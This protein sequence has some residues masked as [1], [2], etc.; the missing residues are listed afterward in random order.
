[1]TFPDASLSI[2]FHVPS[3][4][5]GSFHIAGSRKEMDF[6]AIMYSTAMMTGELFLILFMLNVRNV[7][8]SSLLLSVKIE[9][10]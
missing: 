6:P 2:S 1:M 10:I 4:Y 3:H 5:K 7:G 8:S 9:T